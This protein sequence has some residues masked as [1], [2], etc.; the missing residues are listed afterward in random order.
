MF[1]LA[2]YYVV[3]HYSQAVLDLLGIVRNF[4]WFFKE[5]FSIALLAKTL[6]SPFRRLNEERKVGFDLGAL[7]EKIMV[8]TLMRVVGIVLR[9]TLILLGIACMLATLVFGLAFLIAW[10]LAP[11]ML[12]FMVGAGLTLLTLG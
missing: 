1:G 8:N 4:L 6:F 9:A 11:L 7:F 10:L 2:L 5:F 3:W 12:L